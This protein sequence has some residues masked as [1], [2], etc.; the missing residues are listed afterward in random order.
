[1]DEWSWN[2]IVPTRRRD[3]WIKLELDN[4]NWKNVIDLKDKRFIVELKDRAMNRI[5]LL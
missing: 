4:S 5:L 2:K 1:M 3:W